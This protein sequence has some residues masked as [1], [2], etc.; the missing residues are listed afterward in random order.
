MILVCEACGGDGGWDYVVGRDPNGP[1]WRWQECTR[2][3]GRG[4]LEIDGEPIT[5]EDLD[6]MAGEVE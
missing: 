4:D 1:V 3:L 6:A 5:L 2:C